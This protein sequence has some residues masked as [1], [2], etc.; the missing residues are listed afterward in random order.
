MS[1]LGQ[2]D[3]LL[4][5]YRVGTVWVSGVV[6]DAA[7]QPRIGLSAGCQ[8]QETPASMESEKGPMG[9][10]IAAIGDSYAGDPK[11][12]RWSG[13]FPSRRGSITSGR[14]R[15]L[16]NNRSRCPAMRRTMS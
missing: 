15:T 4:H 10:R 9:F 11:G 13:I 1:R 7:F 12:A 16:T 8:L 5:N 2:G 3:L 6:A 14:H